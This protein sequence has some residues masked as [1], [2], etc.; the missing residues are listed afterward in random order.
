MDERGSYILLGTT[1]STN[2][3]LTIWDLGLSNRRMH[4]ESLGESNQS[5]EA[6]GLSNGFHCYIGE[7]IKLNH[8]GLSALVPWS[9][10][11]VDEAPIA[12]V[13]ERVLQ[14]ISE[15][16][17]VLGILFDGLEH[18]AWELFSELE[19]RAMIR[20]DKENGGRSSNGGRN[21]QKPKNLSWGLSYDKGN[22]SNGGESERK[23]RGSFVVST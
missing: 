19:K 2:G 22:G 21:S 8:D 13:F 1:C 9:E 18:L 16:S 10:L 6:Q 4:T 7:T 11:D 17:D 12:S 20:P 23:S 14:K 5:I 15:V 3:R